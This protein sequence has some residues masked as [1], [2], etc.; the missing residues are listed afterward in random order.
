MY[1][2]GTMHARCQGPYGTEEDVTAKSSERVTV[3]RPTEREIGQTQVC[4]QANDR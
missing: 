2:S 1:M 4:S 3:D